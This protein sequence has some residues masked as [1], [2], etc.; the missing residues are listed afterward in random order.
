M[1]L[2]HCRDAR[3]FRPLWAMEEMAIAYELVNL[4]FPPRVKVAGYLDINP[5]GT[6]PTFIDN[7][8]VMTES[9]AICQYLAEKYQASH[10]IVS[11]KDA[12]YGEYLNWLYRSDTT[13]TFPQAL[14]LRYERYEPEERRQPQVA[15]DY[16]KWL[17]SRLRSVESQLDNNE[18]LCADKF[19]LAD[20]CVGYALYLAQLTAIDSHFGPNT[21]AYLERLKHRDA[22]QSALTRQQDLAPIF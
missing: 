3:S 4:P 10:L 11:P 16:R 15:Q 2:Y 1:K 6:V 21:K 17:T 8:L 14:I 19:T 9:V 18:Y 12:E 20:I 5:L 22:F 13:F 7:N